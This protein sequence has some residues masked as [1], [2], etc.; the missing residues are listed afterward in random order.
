MAQFHADISRSLENVMGSLGLTYV[1]WNSPDLTELDDDA[2]SRPIWD[3]KKFSAFTQMPLVSSSHYFTN[4]DFLSLP[5]SIKKGDFVVSIEITPNRAFYQL[6]KKK[7]PPTTALPLKAPLLLAW[8]HIFTEDSREIFE[9]F[10][11]KLDDYP[12][13][14]E[15]VFVPDNENLT[16][17]AGR[18]DLGAFLEDQTSLIETLGKILPKKA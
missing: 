9:N 3:R 6:D 16:G 10:F 7:S 13:D 18:F 12:Y 17:W 4:R 14:V 5:R 11:C 15:G 2:F 8:A 1:N